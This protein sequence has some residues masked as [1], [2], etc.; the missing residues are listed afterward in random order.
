M[1]GAYAAQPGT[2]FF[3]E[4]FTH[5]HVASSCV[6]IPEQVVTPIIG[7]MMRLPTHPASASGSMREQHM[8]LP[9]YAIAILASASVG[10]ACWAKQQSFSKRSW[11]VRVGCEDTRG[12]QI[13]YHAPPGWRIIRYDTG[14][15]GLCGVESHTANIKAN[16]REKP[17]SVVAAGTITG[18]NRGP[19]V[20]IL[21]HRIAACPSRG[22]GW[23]QVAGI[24]AR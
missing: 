11:L 18:R 5:A 3:I 4:D 19:G 13:E 6:F 14:W 15:V 12:T 22:R 24:I 9:I 17:T 8:R 16:S 2:R 7:T 23:L 1:S 10:T 20:R 21:G